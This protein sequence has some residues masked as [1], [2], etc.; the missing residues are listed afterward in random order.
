[1]QQVTDYAARL[2]AGEKLS[3]IQAVKTPKGQTYI[4]DGHHRYMAS[5][6][7]GIP[8]EVRVIE[9]AGPVGFPNWND[10]RPTGH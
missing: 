10:V 1:M 2:Q 9:G 5:Q 8:V 6:V 4:T 3:P 7:T